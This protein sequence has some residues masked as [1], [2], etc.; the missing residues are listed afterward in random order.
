MRYTIHRLCK[1]AKID[2]FVNDF[3]ED[4]IGLEARALLLFPANNKGNTLQVFVKLLVSL[5]Q[6]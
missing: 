4:D 3:Y 2:L 5:L 1:R 6:F